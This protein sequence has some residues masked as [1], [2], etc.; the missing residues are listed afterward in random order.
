MAIYLDHN[1]TTAVDPQVFE[2]MVPFLRDHFGNPSS[3]HDFGKPVARALETAREQVRA[4]IGAALASEVVFTSGATEANNT[5]ILSALDAQPDRREIITTTVEHPAILAL[6]DHLAARGYRIHKIGVD[7]QGR[8]DVDAFRAALS[9]RVAIASVM[10]ANNETG[11]LFPIRELAEMAHAAGVLMHVDAVQVAGKLPLDVAHSAIDLLSLSAHKFHG[12]KGVG[13]LYVRRGTRFR[14][15]IR[16]GHQERG[17]RAGTENVAGIVGMGVAATLAQ[18]RLPQMRALAGL[19]DQLERALVAAVPHAF[20]VGANSPRVPNTATIAFEYV[21]GE[22][23]LLLLNAVGIAASSGSACTS[24]ALEP[25]HVLRAMDIPYTAAH[26]AI[27]F[28]LGHASTAAE[29]DAVID[30]VPGVIDRLRQ[31]SPY[32]DGTGPRAEAF[33]PQFNGAAA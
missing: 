3:I 2:A 4:F 7:G 14:P 20:V 16:G 6:C 18:A 26:G 9:P 5:A 19:R 11:V 31:L 28:S 25:S 17:R 27:R 23:I 15:L 22:A 10:A 21:E 13:A 12:P 32:W 30:A 33:N 8:L 24:G 1:A 29:I